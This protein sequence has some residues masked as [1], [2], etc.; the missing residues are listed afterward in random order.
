MFDE[1]KQYLAEQSGSQLKGVEHL[2]TSKVI[3]AQ[4][5]E[6]QQT[7]KAKKT[8]DYY[9][10]LSELEQEQLLKET[11]LREDHHQK[12]VPGQKPLNTTSKSTAQ[13]YEQNM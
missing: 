11:K 3:K 7:V 8:D 10:K 13:T 4:Q 12:V 1:R 9:S 2:K 5:P 6:W